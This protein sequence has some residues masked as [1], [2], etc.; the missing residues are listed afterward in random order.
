MFSEFDY[1]FNSHKT[2]EQMSKISIGL[3]A[4]NIIFELQTVPKITDSPA[5]MTISFNFIIMVY[6]LVQ[7]LGS[8]IFV[9]CV[10]VKSLRVIL[11]QT[12]NF[13]ILH[14]AESQLRSNTSRAKLEQNVVDKV[15]CVR[16]NFRRYVGEEMICIGNISSVYPYK[17][18]SE[19]R[20]NG[21]SNM[22]V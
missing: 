16:S 12:S 15:C 4:L 10:C 20:G 22:C 11:S 8:I 19:I 13:K 21:N 14:V 18:K 9:V 2:S 5:F 6:F 17:L 1:Q 3:C 7:V